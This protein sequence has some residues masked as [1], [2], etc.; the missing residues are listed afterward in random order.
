MSSVARILTT[1][2]LLLAGAAAALAQADATLTVEGEIRTIDSDGD[3][4]LWGR[5]R[6]YTNVYTTEEST[7][8]DCQSGDVVFGLSHH[9]VDWGSAADA[10]PAGTWVCDLW[11]IPWGCD[12]DRPDS[13]QDYMSCSGASVDV[14]PD[15]HVGWVARP[16]QESLHWGN[17][18]FEYAAY[19]SWKS[20]NSLPVWCCRAADAT[21]EAA[22]SVG[23]DA[24]TL[25]AT[26][27]PRLWGRG[28]PNTHV[29]DRIEGSDTPCMRD[30]VTFGLSRLAVDWG[31]AADACPEG[32]WVCR[33]GEMLACDTDRPDAS[34]DGL[35]CSGSSHNW[36][37]HQHHGWTADATASST[38]EN[39]LMGNYVRED[40]GVIRDAATCESLPVWC[41]R[42]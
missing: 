20:C 10:C 26:G 19:G 28:R 30:D 37:A 8:E 9:I 24:R 18:V 2:G 5:G 14:L 25:T 35:S 33:S 38:P 17:V 12:T 13:N 41:C 3:P 40:S 34:I 31:S 42:H 15:R 29:Y 6:P 39:R 11:E 32:W 21:G 4:R 7:G 36:E 23:G 1:L 16:H 22:L 27:E